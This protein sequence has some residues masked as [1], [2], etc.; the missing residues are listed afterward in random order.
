MFLA[1]RARLLKIK[2]QHGFEALD[3]SRALCSVH[4]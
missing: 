1:V 4:I 3:V 2:E